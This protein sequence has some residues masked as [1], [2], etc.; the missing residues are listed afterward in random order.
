MRGRIAL[1]VA[2]VV[3]SAL[4]LVGGASG[5][6]AALTVNGGATC[7]SLPGRPPGS[8]VT[9]RGTGFAPS[10]TV[11]LRGTSDH[12]DTYGPFTATTDSS[13]AFSLIVVQ[14]ISEN[15]RDTFSADDGKGHQ[16]SVGYD[17]LLDG[18]CPTPTA[19][20]VPPTPSPAPSPTP[21]PHLNMQAA[22]AA[23]GA[24]LQALLNK[25]YGQFVDVQYR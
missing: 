6:D 1:A 13:G 20:P 12:G 17:A 22:T 7:V 18:T 3:L 11:T 25:C 24:E 14:W 4:A 23:D 19:T 9:F 2:V 10:S 16:A 5:A 21:T 8:P 15:Q